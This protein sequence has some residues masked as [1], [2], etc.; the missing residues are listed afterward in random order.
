MHGIVDVI[1]DSRIDIIIEI[2]IF[3]K[4]DI[5]VDCWHRH[6]M[7]MLIVL[8]EGNTEKNID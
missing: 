6:M 7:L 5:G 3:I 2:D 4:S 8:V 1:I